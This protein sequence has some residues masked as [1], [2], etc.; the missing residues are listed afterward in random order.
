MYVGFYFIIGCGVEIT[1]TII[2]S[3]FFL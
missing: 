2:F 1:E 3:D